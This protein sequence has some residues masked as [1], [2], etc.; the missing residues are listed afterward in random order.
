MVDREGFRSAVEPTVRQV[1]ANYRVPGIVVA[2]QRGDE[3]VLDLAV[4]V[5]ARDDPLVPDSIFPVASITKLASALAVLRLVSEGKIAL[6]GPLAA[7]V[8]DAAAAQPGVTIRRL[9]SHSAGLPRDLSPATVS[10]SLGLDWPTLSRG[11]RETPLQ[12]APGTRVHYSNVGYGLL[13][14]VVERVTGKEFSAVLQGSVLD[15]LQIDGSL[16]GL[17]PRTPVAISDVRG[18]TAG[19]DREMFNSA[20]WRSLGL[21]WAGLTTTAAGALALV[22]AFRAPSPTL[23]PDLCVEATRN[24]DDDLPGGFVPPLVWPTCWWGLGPD[25]RD[26]K[27]PHWTPLEA[28]PQTYGH[29][30]ASG[31]CVWE[32]PTRGVRWAILGTRSADNGWLVRAGSRLGTIVLHALDRS[33]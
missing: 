11:C 29:S 7:R 1:M 4:G 24:Q 28:S 13:A 2:A 22:R 17:L 21:P 30:G 20:F 8:P 3:P 32:D 9:L 18:D 12:F 19:S 10:Y 16:T 14:C 31:C 27:T 5:D 6:D 23:P 15:P 25:L 26:S 33:S